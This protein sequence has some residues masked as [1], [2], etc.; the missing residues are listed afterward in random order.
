MPAL[1]AGDLDVRQADGLEGRA[2]ELRLLA[3]DLLQAQ[4]IGRL[5]IDS[6][7]LT[8]PEASA[9]GIRR[10]LERHPERRQALLDANPAYVFF[11]ELPADGPGPWP[12]SVSPARKS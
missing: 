4:D 6:G 3:L 9:Q 12:F 11:R 10:W 1:L 8:L 2:R 7:E 5:L